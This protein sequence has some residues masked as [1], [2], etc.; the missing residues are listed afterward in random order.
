MIM[1]MMMMMVTIIMTMLITMMM[2]M[3]TWHFYDKTKM[4]NLYLIQQA[5]EATMMRKRRRVQVMSRNRRSV[6]IGN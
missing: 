4:R 3:K 1:M 6:V 2:T 5:E